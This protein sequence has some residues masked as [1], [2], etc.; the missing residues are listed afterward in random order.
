MLGEALQEI[1]QCV[2][3]KGFYVWITIQDSGRLDLSFRSRNF[4]RLAERLRRLQAGEFNRGSGIAPMMALSKEVDLHLFENGRILIWRLGNHPAQIIDELVQGRKPRQGF[5][6][7]IVPNLDLFG[8][9]SLDY[10]HLGRLLHKVAMLNP[11]SKW[12]FSLHSR[13]KELFQT[14]AF[15]YPRGVAVQMDAWSMDHFGG[16]PTFRIDLQKAIG[17]LQYQISISYW[18]IELPTNFKEA[19]ANLDR[20]R[21]GSS[22]ESGV[23]AGIQKAIK[24]MVAK[25]KRKLPIPLKQLSRQLMVIAAVS[26]PELDWEGATRWSREVPNHKLP[27]RDLVCGELL[28]LFKKDREILRQVLS[29]FDLEAQG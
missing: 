20:I 21:D 14:T 18:P 12:K 9:G 4:G 25:Q 1:L 27:V 13:K 6:L 22:L 8:I 24:E 3:S 7:R 10:G 29:H 23:I 17:N 26:A 5:S 2:G 11:G 28:R 15:Q 16:K 19:Y